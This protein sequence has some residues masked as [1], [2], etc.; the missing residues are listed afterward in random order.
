[1]GPFVNITPI[2]LAGGKGTRLRSVVADR[3]KPLALVAGKPF[4][5]YL[6]EQ[7][8]SV[9]FEK[10][11]IASG[12]LGEQFDSRFGGNYKNLAI[13]YSQEP[14]SLGTAGALRYALPH[15]ATSRLLVL[16]GDSFCDIDLA[17]L[18]T[19][20][21]QVHACITLTAVQVPDSG[22]YGN[23]RMHPDGKVAAFVEKGAQAG[24]G[25]INAGVYLLDRSIIETLESG[26]ACSLEHEVLPTFCNDAMYAFKTAGAFI[27]IGIP[28]DYE[29]AQQL[30]THQRGGTENP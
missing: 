2:V 30:F 18:V 26:V 1:M 15:V 20:H 27:D 16:N 9:G 5:T 13:E 12:Y 29:R 14:F 3:P 21:E 22:R 17:A 24:P 8:V 4:V 25:Y 28:E 11:V 10:V 19:Y 6:L 23:I 7:L